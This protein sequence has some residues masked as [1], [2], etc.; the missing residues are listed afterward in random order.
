MKKSFIH[1]LFLLV[2]NIPALSQEIRYDTT[3][4]VTYEN[5]VKD[6]LIVIYK[7]VTLTEK[8]YIIDSTRQNRWA[9]DVFASP[10]FS[11]LPN[12]INSFYSEKD[13]SNTNLI[14]KRTGQSIGSHLYYKNKKVHFRTGI[15]LSRQVIQISSDQISQSHTTTTYTV[16]D[17]ISSYYGVRPNNDT[18]HFYIIEPKDESGIDT[19][20]SQD[21]KETSHRIYYFEIP[22]Q[23]GYEMNLEKWNISFLGGP[24]VGFI[25]RS[26]GFTFDKTGK[27]MPITE[28]ILPSPIFHLQGNMQASYKYNSFL[29]IYAEPYF[30]KQLNSFYSKN[31]I[32]YTSDMIGFRVGLKCFL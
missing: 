7:R 20:I 14:E 23:I 13:L 2:I 22:V 5:G 10:F 29:Q 19:H 26:G 16:N 18:V 12:A 30:Q 31:Q 28:A 4:R 27:I 8:V 32:M 15:N 24:M 17:T 25:F 11:A 1:L 6:S 21:K 9:F 3:Y